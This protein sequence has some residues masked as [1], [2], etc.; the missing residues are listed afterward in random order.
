MIGYSLLYTL[1]AVPV[2]LIPYAGALILL[3]LLPPL[4]AGFTIVALA[5]LKGRRWTFGDFFGGFH[6]YGAILGNVLLTSLI[7]L[8]CMLPGLIAV[9]AAAPSPAADQAPDQPS[10]P[11]GPL[12]T[13]AL[14]FAFINLLLA[15]YINLRCTIFSMPLVIDRGCGPVQAIRGSWALSKGHFWGLLGVVLLLSLINLGGA[16]LC[17]IGM[18]FTLPLT[19]LVLTAGYLLIAGTRPP[20]GSPAVGAVSE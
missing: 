10:P 1:I 7:A 5:Q 9:I 15:T 6:R 14:I 16:L 17:G 2:A 12:F 8:A 18:L 13:G 19:Q 11:A 3:F 20:V 4:A